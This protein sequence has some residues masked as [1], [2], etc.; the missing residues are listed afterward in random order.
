M[1]ENFQFEFKKK[2]KSFLGF[3][4]KNFPNGVM[5]FFGVGAKNRMEERW[6]KP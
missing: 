2:E 6:G 3:G 4:K 1:R 5:K